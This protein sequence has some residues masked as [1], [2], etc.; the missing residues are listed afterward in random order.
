MWLGT[1]GYPL[2]K[3]FI[4][5]SF[6][7][8][9]PWYYRMPTLAY[10]LSVLVGK[11][12]FPKIKQNISHAFFGLAM[13]S[14]LEYLYLLTKFTNTPYA[15]YYFTGSFI[16]TLCFLVS[17]KRRNHFIIY[18]ATCFAGYVAFLINE[19]LVKPPIVH[20]NVF[21][22]FTFVVT[23]LSLVSIQVW[24]NIREHNALIKAKQE[25][26]V[27]QA[28]LVNSSK[29]AAL[30]EM[31]GGIAHEINNPLQVI[32]GS[33]ELLEIMPGAQ[34]PLDNI[35]ETVLRI[36]RIVEGLRLF[37]RDGDSTSNEPTKVEDVVNET[38][39]LCSEKFKK[40]GISL[41]VDIDPELY[42][43]CNHIEISRV[44][45]NLLN[46]AFDAIKENGKDREINISASTDKKDKVQI[47][48]YDSGVNIDKA[49]SDK[50][51]QPFFT[52]KALGKGTGLGLSISKGVIE[53]HGGE[54]FLEQNPKC[55]V[56]KLPVNGV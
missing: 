18:L 34:E 49:T 55:F 6:A 13:I 26:E 46:N 35:K 42:V 38:L 12:Y 27:K 29:L 44:F 50:L 28:Q 54:L 16:V 14:T 31:A 39:S 32:S 23:A 43:K 41:N 1:L 33:V 8:I 3:I 47:R 20:I 2:F 22:K 10:G 30:G 48:F 21:N 24:N 7:D 19:V 5:I 11:E 25:L 37:S 51:F 45:L 15:D 53:K 9:E 17:F 40:N 52:T 4:H 36:N 56:V